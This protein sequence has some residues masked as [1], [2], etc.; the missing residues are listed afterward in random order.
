MLLLWCFGIIIIAECPEDVSSGNGLAAEPTK[1]WTTASARRLF[2]K[3]VLKTIDLTCLNVIWV[4]KEDVN[5]SEN[6]V[7]EGIKIATRAMR[8]VDKSTRAKWLNGTDT[9]R[10]CMAKLISKIQR[11]GIDPC[12]KFEALCFYATMAGA[13]GL[14]EELVT[15]YLSLLLGLQ[16]LESDPETLRDTL[17]NSLPLYARELSQSTIAQLL[18]NIFKSTTS[19]QH[20]S[21]L[22]N[23][24][25]LVDVLLDLGADS[26]SRELT[27]TL[28]SSELQEH[29]RD[30]LATPIETLGAT[31]TCDTSL[32]LL[33]RDVYTRTVSMLLTALISAGTNCDQSASAIGI[34]LIKKQQQ[35]PFLNNQCSH[36]KPIPSSKISL[37][38]QACTP[39]TGVQRQ[40]WRDAIGSELERQSHYQRASVIRSVAQICQNLE[41]RCHSV[42]A[43]LRQ[44]QARVKELNSVIAELREKIADMEAE[45]MDRQYFFNSLEA[46]IESGN[47]ERAVLS[48]EKEA[49]TA[50][51]E[52][53]EAKTDDT[54]K[55]KDDLATRLEK[56]KADFDQANEEADEALFRLTENLK[57]KEAELRSTISAHEEA[58]YSRD[59]EIG[60][61]NARYEELEDELRRLQG[62]KSSLQGLYENLKNELSITEKDLQA[63]RGNLAA[64]SE[65]ME[66]LTVRQSDL[67]ERLATAEQRL[68]S[69]IAQRDELTEQLSQFSSAQ[70][71]L[72]GRLA[73]TNQKLNEVLNERNELQAQVERSE[74]T[75]QDLEARRITELD[76][77]SSKVNL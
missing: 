26:M 40:D 17:L 44:E 6:D 71:T 50:T 31:E 1:Q 48:K 51:I 76:A 55:E 60:K 69:T 49:L 41:D 39:A 58:L 20:P 45:A 72:E 75:V 59:Q 64:K 13:Q 57:A 77:A 36:P 66:Q 56:L 37:F 11:P 67:E 68:E 5:V 43:P 54:N 73:T 62:E 28:C 35:L 61:F 25:I 23:T 7:V 15:E 52:G 30:F 32:N 4:T 3:Q 33:R 22:Q 12:V 42:E 10:R 21:E 27:M 29:F 46:E 65:E 70:V 47:K 8:F 74:Q 34:A 16:N 19:S 38:E 53:L 9:A 14:R 24:S 18:V 63:E 2:E